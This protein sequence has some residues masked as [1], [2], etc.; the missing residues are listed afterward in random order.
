MAYTLLIGNKNY[1]SWSLRP[2]VLLHAFGIPFAEEL[3]VFE[4]PEFA[5]EISSRKRSPNARVPV[6]VDGD[7]KVWDSLAIAEYLAERHAGLWPANA[8]ARAHARCACA[9]MHSGFQ[10]LRNWMP[11]NVRRSFAIE[12]PRE[13]VQKDIDRMQALWTEARGKFGTSGPFLYGKFS[14]ADAYFAPVVFRFNTYGVKLNPVVTDYAK[15]MLAH[16]SMQQWIADLK[17]EKEVVDHEEPEHIY[18][19][20]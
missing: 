1:S 8:V 3:H 9:E 15:A 14:I 19:T 2:W 7:V 13:D 20:K 18:A 10:A 5:A 16:P 4:T 11:M 12:V 17:A 6:L